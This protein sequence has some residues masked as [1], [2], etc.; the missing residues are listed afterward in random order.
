M[1][2]TG[3]NLGRENGKIKRVRGKREELVT[4]LREINKK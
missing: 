4:V 1:N 2:K 3:N